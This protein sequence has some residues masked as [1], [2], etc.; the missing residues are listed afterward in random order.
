MNFEEPTAPT[1][2]E[3]KAASRR[4]FAFL[5]EHGFEEVPQPQKKYQNPYEVHFMKEGWRLIVEG[6]SYGFGAGLSVHSPDGR[7]GYFHY[8]IENGFWDSHRN[9]LG[10]GQLGDLKYQRLCL[11]TF[12][13]RFLDGDWREFDTIVERHSRW[14]IENEQAQKKGE[15]ERQMKRAIDEAKE[16]FQDCRFSEA[17]R[18][19]S[20]YRDQLPP[21]QKKRLEIAEGRANG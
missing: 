3:F 1:L 19:L 15:L 14:R 7:D 8:L 13:R 9:G 18:L 4:E 11:E 10:R 20:P 5:L 17:A 12:G 6:H 16:L 2:E 21:A